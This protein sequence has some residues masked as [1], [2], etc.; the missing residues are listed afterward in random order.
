MEKEE[1][2][3]F[4][5]ENK[6][7]ETLLNKDETIKDNFGKLNKFYELLENAQKVI[8]DK[9]V[10]LVSNDINYSLKVS[11]FIKS[12]QSNN[13]GDYMKGAIFHNKEIIE[14]MFYNGNYS[15]QNIFIPIIEGFG[16][17]IVLDQ[18]I[19][20]H[21]CISVYSINNDI[22]NKLREEPIK[23]E[24]VNILNKGSDKYEEDADKYYIYSRFV[25]IEKDKPE[26]IGRKIID[27]YNLLK[28]KI[29]K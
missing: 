14:N 7:F 2:K 22:I 16:L 8:L 15:S 13:G 27:L 29:A 1:I 24:I 9:R 17:S 10:E 3:K 23:T 18:I 26:E 19:D 6:Y 25:D 28:E 12:V 4:F 11:E 21:L 20:Y 5:E